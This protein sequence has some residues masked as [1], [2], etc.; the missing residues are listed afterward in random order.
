MSQ[1]GLLGTQRIKFFQISIHYVG[2]VEDTRFTLVYERANHHAHS[3][4]V[5]FVPSKHLRNILLLAPRPRPEGCACWASYVLC[6]G[7][8]TQRRR[9]LAD[10]G[11]LESNPRFPR[12]KLH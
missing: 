11:H 5:P 10:V 7:I 3:I 9:F 4:F 2:D 8:N 1:G 12:T 6:L